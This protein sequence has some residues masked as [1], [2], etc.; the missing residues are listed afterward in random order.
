MYMEVDMNMIFTQVLGKCKRISISAK[1]D[2]VV[3]KQELF[4]WFPLH[5]IPEFSNSLQDNICKFHIKF[6]KHNNKQLISIPWSMIK[7]IPG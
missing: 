2:E 3:G 5:P 7:K 6:P 4:D 1:F